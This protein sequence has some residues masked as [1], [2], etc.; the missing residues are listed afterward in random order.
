M[1]IAAAWLA[2][3]GPLD[4]AEFAVQ[5]AEDRIV[6]MRDGQP[7]GEYVF[8][9]PKIPR[10]YWTRLRVRMA[11]RSRVGIRQSRARMPSITTRCIRGCGSRLVI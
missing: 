11:R 3:L 8:R 5:R 2:D 10:P 1:A 4:A 7:V 6:V 9:D